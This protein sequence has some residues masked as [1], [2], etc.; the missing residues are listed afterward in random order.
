M[1]LGQYE[2]CIPVRNEKE[3]I[4]WTLDSINGQS[5][6]PYRINICLNGTTDDTREVI[7]QYG[8]SKVRIVESEPGKA[9]AWN[10]LFHETSSLE[11]LL[12]CDGD[13]ALSPNAAER[14]FEKLEENPNL[15]IVGGGVCSISTNPSSFFSKYFMED[16]TG[17]KAVSLPGV[18][19]Q[20]YGIHRKRLVEIAKEKRLPLLPTNIINDDEYLSRL[21]DSRKLITTKAYVTAYGASNFTDWFERNNRIMKGHIQLKRQFPEIFTDSKIGR[22]RIENYMSR[23][24]EVESYLNKIGLSSLYV[25][26]IGIK[27]WYNVFPPNFES[28]DYSAIW[29]GIPSTK[30]RFY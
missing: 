19:G 15:A 6:L 10:K 24:T 16:P 5:H 4:S 14:I 2:V 29:E 26:R 7:E 9:N 23:L 25:A 1:T 8:D 3:L 28:S 17:K 12:F 22:K 30:G 13:V 18:S 21:V 11:Q 27:V 20:L